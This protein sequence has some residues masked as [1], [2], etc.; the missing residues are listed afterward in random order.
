MSF[1]E[2]ALFPALQKRF[3]EKIFAKHIFDKGLVYKICKALIK[4]NS[5]ITNNPIYNGQKK[6]WKSPQSRYT[7]GTHKRL[8][9]CS[10]SYVIKD[11]KLK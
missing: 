1:R 8:K 9:R 3:W 10:A 2:K 6:T 7:H 11:S 5:K 4:L